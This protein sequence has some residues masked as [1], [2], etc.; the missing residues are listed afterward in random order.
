MNKLSEDIV[1][2]F[3]YIFS[4]SERVG[5]DDTLYFVAMVASRGEAK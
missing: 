4:R 3:G 5:M 1:G 2:L